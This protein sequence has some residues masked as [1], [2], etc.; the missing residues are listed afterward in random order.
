ML[1]LAIIIGIFAINNSGVVLID[2]V[3][4]EVLLSQAIVIFLCAL[5]GALVA[6]I[7]GLIRQMTLKKEIKQLSNKNK[8]LQLQVDELTV[9]LV[10]KEE[11][12]SVLTP[13]EDSAMVLEPETDPSSGDQLPNSENMI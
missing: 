11:E 1:V 12:L 8:A 4:T 2:F 9:K 10:T 6:T 5:L 7:F 3:F 13:Q